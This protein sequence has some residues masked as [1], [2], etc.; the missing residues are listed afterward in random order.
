[1]S[2]LTS[3]A[4]VC[5]LGL[6]PMAVTAD[7]KDEL[8]LDGRYTVVAGER[9]GKAMAEKDINGSVITVN[10]DKIVGTNKDGGEFLN[11]TFALDQTKKPC[12]VTL[13]GT[14]SNAGKSWTGLCERTADGFRVIY[15]MEGGEA[16]TEFKT[17]EKQILLTLKKADK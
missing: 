3:L 13:K 1:V 2:K 4:L 15:Q 5:S 8:K 12:V 16:P 7:D 10:A 9:E 6:A 17:K 11:C 14:G